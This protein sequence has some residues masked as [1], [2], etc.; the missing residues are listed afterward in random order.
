MPVPPVSRR[1]FLK[2][3]ALL[4]AAALPWPYFRGMPRARTLAADRPNFLILVL[5]ALSARHLGLHGYARDTT[6]NLARFAEQAVVYHAHRAAGN[7]TSSG[8][9]SLLTGTYPWSHRAL[10]LHSTVLEPFVRRNL[11]ALFDG[12][13]YHRLGYSHNLLVMS[14]LHQFQRDLDRFI[15]TR[16]LCLVD[17]QLADRVFSADYNAAFW[18]EWLYLRGSD[19]P[20]GSLYFSWL[21]RLV[22]GLHRRRLDLD[23]LA[24]FPR[25]VP[26][27]HNLFFLLEDAIDWMVAQIKA[28]PR[29]YLAYIHLLPPHEPYTTRHDFVDRFRDGLRNAEKPPHA[30]GGRHPPDF[31]NRQRRWYDEY[32]AYADAE[33]GRLLDFMQAGGV[34]EDTVVLITS[35]HGELF[36]RGMVGHVTPTLFEPVIHVPLLIRAPGIAERQDV[37]SPTSAVDVLPTLLHLAGQ[38]VPAWVEGH[39]LPPFQQAEGD[40]PVFALEAKSNPRH[41]PLSK[42]SAVLIR[43]Q[44]KLVHYFGYPNLDAA[45][46]L[47]DLAADPEELE[48]R[49]SDSDRAAEL[50]AEL[51]DKLAEVNRPWLRN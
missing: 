25:G 16:E 47:Y 8:T 46:E 51:L 33:F 37:R 20:P 31:V 50:E 49:F 18:S 9:A 27:L 28:L 23:L 13:G 36:E 29:P 34:F 19:A 48:N 6:P 39:T 24:Q 11:F 21:H 38:P 4:P 35:D 17:D 32:L 41:A 30:L 40:R 3:A 45:F 1:D 44:H 12:L 22:R 10:H 15:P 5:D 2:L 7:F 14:L 42:G 43:G 26:A